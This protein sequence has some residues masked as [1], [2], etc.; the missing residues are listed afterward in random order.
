MLV[1]QYFFFVL[2][3]NIVS[4]DVS[5]LFNLNLIK[6]WNIY[7]RS[8]EI[9]TSV[10]FLNPKK[11]ILQFKYFFSIFISTQNVLENA[12][13]L[14]QS[15]L[16]NFAGFSWRDR[17]ADQKE[18]YGGDLCALLVTFWI[19]NEFWNQ[20]NFFCDFQTISS[21]KRLITVKKMFE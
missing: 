19:Q 18:T 13:I 20:D 21:N 7:C 17:N 1:L 12:V 10:H 3:L 8:K 6:E 2:M 4:T 11:I 15:Q 14:S 9:P 16:F 5:E